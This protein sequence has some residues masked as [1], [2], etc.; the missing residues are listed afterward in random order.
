MVDPVRIIYEHKISYHAKQKHV[1]SLT[2]GPPMRR[3]SKPLSVGQSGVR[4]R[5][6]S[7]RVVLADFPRYQ[8]PERR[9]IRMFA[10]TKTR[11]KV[12]ADVPWYQQPEQG[13]IRKPPF[14]ETA[15]L[16]QGVLQGAAFTG[17]QVSRERRLIS[18]H[19]KRARRTAE[20][21]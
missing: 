15:L 11:T 9:Y 6:V 14:Y 21:K 1:T 2:S 7:K 5:V 13:Y 19:E 12:H 3:E 18:L 16:F 10:G 4:K 20:M 17:V 8:K